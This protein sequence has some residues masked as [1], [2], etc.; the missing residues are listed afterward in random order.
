MR[1]R[2]WER[3]DLALVALQWCL[4]QNTSAL[5]LHYKQLPVAPLLQL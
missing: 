3:F 4:A 5:L 1:G 2:K